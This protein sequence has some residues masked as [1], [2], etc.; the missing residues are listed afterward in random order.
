MKTRLAVSVS[1][2]AVLAAIGW[3]YSR[4]SGG[5]EKSWKI[6]TSGR[7]VL[8]ITSSNASRE[9]LPK[10]SSGVPGG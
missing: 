8:P 7:Q 10:V 2:V 1:I 6:N 5:S 4:S 3:Y 9:Q